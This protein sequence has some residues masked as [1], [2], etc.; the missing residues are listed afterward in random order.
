MAT[1]VLNKRFH[2]SKAFSG[3]ARA[4]TMAFDT[5]GNRRTVWELNHLS[6]RQL[7]DL[8]IKRDEIS[9]MIYR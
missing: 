5:T 1:L 2:F 6:D 7:D 9:S 8:G 3:L 4:I